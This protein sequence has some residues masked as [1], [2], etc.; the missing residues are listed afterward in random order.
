MFLQTK[1]GINLNYAII[2]CGITGSAI[3]YQ[4]SRIDSI[5]E[6]VIVDKNP[7]NINRV[8]ELVGK[9]VKIKSYCLDP[10]KDN[11]FFQKIKNTK[12]L[13]NS[14]S[15]L[16]NIK[17]M[18][19]CIKSATNYIDLASNPFPYPGIEKGTTLDE[20]LVLNE[21]FRRSGIVAITN[22]GFSPGFTDIISK[23][24]AVKY[25]L[26]RINSIQ[27]YF[28]ERIGSEK[29]VCSWSPYILLLEVL[30]PPTIY[31]D[32]KIIELDF[33]DAIGYIDFPNPIGRIKTRVFSGHPELR[34]IPEFIGLP[35]DEIKIGGGMYLNNLELS[36]MIAAALSKQLRESVIFKGD[37][38]EILSK[39]FESAENFDRN[40][41]NGIIKYEYFCGTISITGK[42]KDKIIHYNLEI[43]ESI[44]NIIKKIPCG[45]IAS[46]VV[47][48]LPA[49]IAHMITQKK[50][51]QRGVIVPGQLTEINE[52]IQRIRG[53]GLNMKETI[54]QE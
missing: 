35:V 50:I 42:S 51:T 46:Y 12:V 29:L 25:S 19:D 30:S 11:K 14:A 26:D 18:K 3:A 52:I 10:L 22:T 34:T 45:S 5:K 6:L 32:G 24:L 21:K 36:D 47:S 17:L 4:L 53:M 16:C 37:V 23:N 54:R 31:R 41:K 40:Y 44:E 2:G 13:I 43:N 20:Q 33:N 39:S 48:F 9:K 8:N 28:G 1:E 15:P 49:V 27:I 38:F 7:E